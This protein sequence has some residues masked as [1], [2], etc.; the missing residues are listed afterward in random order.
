MAVRYALLLQDGKPT[1]TV[2]QD[3]SE[4]EIWSDSL[5]GL[6]YRVAE[7]LDTMGSYVFSRLQ[8]DGKLVFPAGDVGKE[9][10]RFQIVR[11]EITSVKLLA[12]DLE[13]LERLKSDPDSSCTAFDDDLS[14]DDYED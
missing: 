11:Q 7:W 6:V 3:D 2:S 5:E 8:P 4:H 13:E 10:Q 14:D 12:S 9:E 1:C